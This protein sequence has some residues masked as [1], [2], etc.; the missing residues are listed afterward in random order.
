MTT[1]TS[2]SATGT[3]TW[4]IDPA[5][6][7]VEFSVKHL[8]I[9]SVRGRFGDVKGAIAVDP[10][11]PRA[12]RVDIEI[13]TATIDTRSTD[14]DAHLRSPDFFDSERFPAI[15][16]TSTRIDGDPRGD[17]KLVGDLTIRDVTREVV[18]DAEFEGENRDPWGNDRM[19]FEARGKV[20]RREYGL[21]WNQALE[22][23]GVLVGDD[24]KLD[25][26]VQLV[27]QAATA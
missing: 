11:N 8:M 13:P 26:E 22:A 15:R 21:T 9:S 4:T 24:I 12:T 2:N 19:A 10:A 1:A 23:G 16:F 17:F 3:T 27:K 7:R 5:H 18:L 6:S 25:I 20:N 14:R